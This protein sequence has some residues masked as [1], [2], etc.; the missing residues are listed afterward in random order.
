MHPVARFNLGNGD[1]SPKVFHV[2]ISG[3]N[4]EGGSI[5]FEPNPFPFWNNN[6]TIALGEVGK[7]IDLRVIFRRG[8]SP[9]HR[10]RS[11]DSFSIYVPRGTEIMNIDNYSFNFRGS[12]E[13]P[14]PVK[15]LRDIP[16]YINY[17]FEFL[18]YQELASNSS[19]SKV[20]NFSFTYRGKQ[21]NVRLILSVW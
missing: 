10:P 11:I 18:E 14:P 5:H 21:F 12:D 19:Y 7:D 1:S 2:N 3:D 16:D 8:G 20:T 6:N 15:T 9:F 17:P 4:G 13:I